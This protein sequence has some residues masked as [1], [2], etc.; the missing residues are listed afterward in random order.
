MARGNEVF[1]AEV[2]E[3]VL[4]VEVAE[5]VLLVDVTTDV[6]ESGF[7]LE[8]D[9][10][11]VLELAGRHW[12]Y[13]SKFVRKPIVRAENV[14]YR[15]WNTRTNIQ[16]YKPSHQTNPDL[17]CTGVRVFPVKY[18]DLPLTPSADSLCI[19]NFSRD[20]EKNGSNC[21]D[22]HDNAAFGLRTKEKLKLA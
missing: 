10:G 9:R 5:E 19:D 18:F 11:V 16:M 6:L 15:R 17:R 21:D 14:T 12:L 2:A 4:L 13:P 3:E 22:S 8:D 20:S 1:A 7:V